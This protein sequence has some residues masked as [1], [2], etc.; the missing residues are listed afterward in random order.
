MYSSPPENLRLSAWVK[1][2]TLLSQLD[3][4]VSNSNTERC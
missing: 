1:L 3:I 4:Q 2:K